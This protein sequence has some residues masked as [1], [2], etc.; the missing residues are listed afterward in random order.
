MLGNNYFPNPNRP[1]FK[2]EWDAVA[3]YSFL[4][5]EASEMEPEQVAKLLP[6]NPY[7]GL[8]FNVNA[9]IPRLPWKLGELR[10][11]RWRIVGRWDCPL[12]EVIGLVKSPDHYFSWKD[13]PYLYIKSLGDAPVGQLIGSYS[14]CEGARYVLHNAVRVDGTS[15]TAERRWQEY[16]LSCRYRW[17]DFLKQNNPRNKT[18]IQALQKKLDAEAHTLATTDSSVL[19]PPTV[20]LQLRL[21][22]L[23][24]R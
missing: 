11:S 22:W 19:P 3:T 24:N 18:E 5:P 6:P 10:G 4:P 15:P 1:D 12:V 23:N 13:A 16:S 14:G 17:L 2:G 21:F 20:L 9:Y 7:Y 8:S